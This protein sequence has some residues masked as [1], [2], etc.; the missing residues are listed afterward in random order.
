MSDKGERFKKGA[1]A[2]LRL[3]I[4]GFGEDFDGVKVAICESIGKSGKSESTKGARV[5]YDIPEAQLV[6]GNTVA[7]E[8]GVKI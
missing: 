1:T 5:Y 3:R 4:V 7:D 6:P 2:Y 8:M